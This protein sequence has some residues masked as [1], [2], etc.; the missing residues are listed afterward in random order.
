[1]L[2]LA[3]FHHGFSQVDENFT[4]GNFTA[5]P[6]WSGDDSLFQVNANFQLQSKGTSGTAKDIYLSTA[7]TVTQGEWRFWVRFNLS[8]SNQNFCKYYLM[9]DSA[10]LK[11]QLNGYYVQLGGITGSNDSIMLMKQK[12]N[13]ITQVIG[14]R[15]ATVSKSNNLVNVRVLRDAAGGWQLFSDTTGGTVFLSEGSGTDNE[16]TQS[17]YTGFFVKFTSSNAA[18][19]Y[20]DNV[21]AGVEMIDTTPPKIDSVNVMNATTLRVKFSEALDETAAT[22][23]SNYSLNNG[24]G[25]PAVAALESGKDNVIILIFST[26]LANKTNYTLTVNGVKDLHDNA[27][28][29]LQSDFTYS[30][31]DT[32]QTYDVLITEIMADPEPAVALPDAEYIEFYNRSTRNISL[33]NWFL[34]YGNSTPIRIPFD[35]ILLPDSFIVLC[36][37]NNL[38]LFAG[39]NNVFG[40]SGFPTLANSGARLTLRDANGKI[41]HSVNYSSSWYAN[42]LKKDGGWSLEM[43]D[44]KNPCGQANNWQAS[45]NSKGGTPAKPNSVRGTSRDKSAPAL[46]RAYPKDSITLTLYFNE[47]LDSTSLLSNTFYFLNNG[48]G[49]PASIKVY[50]PEFSTAD[51]IF[52]QPLQ[53]NTIYHIIADS[54]R[55]CAGNIIET[56]NYADA[57]LPEPFTQH[58]L[59]INEILFNP[60]TGGSDFVELYNNSDK[61]IDLKNVRVANTDDLDSLNTIASIDTSGHIVLPNEFIVITASPENIA[62][63]YFGAD[64]KKM[65]T[66]NLPSFNDDKGTCV[67]ADRITGLRYDEFAYDQKMH[68]ALLD[69][70]NGVSLERIDYNRATS[71]QT[72]WTS[73]AASAGYATPTKR[74]SQFMQT[75]TSN[76]TLSVSPE[77]FSPDADGYN[78]LANIQIKMNESGYTGTISI[79][80]SRG[81]LIKQLTRNAILGT[82]NTFSWDGITDNNTKASIG[83]YVV[84][85]EAF[86]LKGDVIKEKATVVVGAKF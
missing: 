40:L 32:A 36:H 46:L 47:A 61:I 49:N 60:H 42:N 21:Y 20:L 4:D 18:N 3:F 39:I 76:R 67:I 59:I 66:V 70:K 57:G 24:I 33:K 75:Q 62:Q 45:K 51:L 58:E 25:S 81:T 6:A 52:N 82:E 23:S 22:T 11:G 72:N 16:F 29:N 56:E 44:V 53:R 54:I 37:A 14:G 71:D 65:I 43:I 80:D 79:Y 41:I 64:K 55:D 35:F 83:I 69:D 1:M 34:Q 38:A 15:R 85:L 27:S 84:Y 26:A 77:V 12:G 74:N 68:F 30:V 17:S 48:I 28:N 50:A 5:N 73:A 8:P 19:Y 7:S 9:S 63:L 2:L 86:N 78:D 10:N 31:P 13:A